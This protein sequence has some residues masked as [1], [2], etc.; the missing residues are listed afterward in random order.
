MCFLVLAMRETDYVIA[1]TA[2]VNQ[3]VTCVTRQM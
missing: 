3:I 1:N 2:N